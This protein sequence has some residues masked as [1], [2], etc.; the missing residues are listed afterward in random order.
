MTALK[1][2]SIGFDIPETTFLQ[3]TV[4]LAAGMDI[5][6]WVYVEN[7]EADIILVNTDIISCQSAIARYAASG[8]RKEG[9]FI[10][11]SKDC[12]QSSAT[13]LSLQRPVTYPALVS[14]LRELQV[15][16]K[17]TAGAAAPAII[18]KTVPKPESAEPPQPSPLPQ[19]S[20]SPVKKRT[21]AELPT[22]EFRLLEEPAITEEIPV[23]TDYPDIDDDSADISRLFEAAEL[24][25]LYDIVEPADDSSFEKVKP[26][27][28]AAEKTE[29][30]TDQPP[31][32][33]AEHLD[34]T[35]PSPP[36]TNTETDL[37]S[38]NRPAKRFYAA[39]RF[40]GLL[41]DIIETGLATEIT[42]HQFP[43]VRIYPDQQT[44]AT[45]QDNKL[46]AQVF[47][48]LVVEFSSH[49][50]SKQNEREIPVNWQVK[51]LWKLLFLAA[52]HGS[53]GRLMENARIADKL[54]LISEPDYNIVPR[55]PEY[56]AIVNA[57]PA[58]EPVCLKT[59]ADESG[60]TVET[61][62]DFCNACEE[63][64]FIKRISSA[65]PS[66]S[67]TAKPSH[68]GLYRSPVDEPEESDDMQDPG[69]A[70]RI[71]SIFKNNK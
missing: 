42:H 45:P 48:T 39:T 55:A 33:S 67:T 62:I 71:K 65:E 18:N 63:V 61:V 56:E 40:L 17:K 23:E 25:V 50:L 9:L 66:A 70:T 41:K 16:L 28:P 27:Q 29:V 44:Y 12:S 46:S 2:T 53:E 10:S 19:P 59:I 69:L 4:E 51:P 54:Q 5:G 6:Q 35:A 1:T 11:C 47:K 13:T 30:K 34:T 64:Q 43:A 7:Q 60:V 49:E 21:L 58:D 20:S 38:L 22:E 8:H 3:T 68:P 36:L 52:L 32:H 24:S 14:L 26:L 57:M 15:E 31:L 37:L